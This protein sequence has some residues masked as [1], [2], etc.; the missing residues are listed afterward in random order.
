MLKFV[1]VILL[2]MA[3]EASCTMYLIYTD[4]RKAAK[5]ALWC[6]VTILFTSLAVVNYV[7]DKTLIIA[8][9]IGAFLGSFITIK[10]KTKP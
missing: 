3:T 8:A 1:A 5:A 9:V 6:S 2:M 4:K 10:L 7:E